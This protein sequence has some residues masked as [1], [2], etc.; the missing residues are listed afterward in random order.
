ML[1][2]SFA[3]TCTLKAT[4]NFLRA[5][6]MNTRLSI[7]CRD[8]QWR[9]GSLK[10]TFRENE[11]TLSKNRLITSISKC[12]LPLLNLCFQCDAKLLRLGISGGF[13]FFFSFIRSTFLKRFSVPGRSLVA[14]EK[15]N[16][17]CG[18]IGARRASARGSRTAAGNPFFSLA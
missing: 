2:I 4:S 18:L 3:F 6:G 14:K 7:L 16:K 10:T 17:L 13:R 5:I 12:A 9:S 8:A 15:E 1:L 11:T